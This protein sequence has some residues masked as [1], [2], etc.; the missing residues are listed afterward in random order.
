MSDMFLLHKMKLKKFYFLSYSFTLMYHKLIKMNVLKFGGSSVKDEVNIS[1][2]LDILVKRKDK[3]AVVFSAMGGVTDQLI[4]LSQLASKKD[5]SYESKFKELKTRHLSTAKKLL[6][7]KNYQIA[8]E[9]L[10]KTHSNLKKILAGVSILG[11][12]SERTMDYIVSFG[13]RT[14]AFIIALA[15]NERKKKAEYLDARQ[16]IVTDSNHG[17]ASLIKK[18]SYRKIRAYFKNKTSIQIIT[19][20]IASDENGKTTTLGRGGS[21]YTAAILGEALKAKSIE[22][23]TDV[24]GILSADPRK[25]EEAFT[26]P[27]VS[28]QE[29][30]EL[31]HFGAKVIYPP[32]IKPA[33]DSKIPVFIK[34][35]FNPDFKGT[36]IKDKSWS[37]DKPVI[38]ISAVSDVLLLS[39]E[40][41]GMIGVPG[42]AARLFG[43]LAIK[44]INIILI[45]Q[46]SSEHAITF[47]VNPK[48]SKSAIQI[49]ND[50]FSTEIEK[51]LIKEI[52]AESNLSVVAVIGENMK[53]TPGI[54]AKLFS[55]MGRNGINIAAIAQGSSELNISV[56]IKKSQQ[57][58]ALN[59]LHEAF[60]KD[61]TK[62]IH[63]Y[64]VG[65]G[66]IG[67]KLIEQ[68]NSQ[69]EILKNKYG[70]SLQICAMAN[71]RKM[72]FNNVQTDSEN[73]SKRLSSSRKKMNIS[74]FVEHMILENRRNAIFVDNTSSSDVIKEYKNILSNSIS[75]S[76]PNKLGA[77]SIIKDFNQLKK[78]AAQ[79]SVVYGYETNVGAGLPILSTIQDLIKS[80]DEIQKI[81][82]VLSGS[83]SYIFNNFNG[84]Q[85]FS[86]IVSEAKEK[87]LTEPD[88]RDDLNGYDVRRKILILARE[89]GHSIEEKEINIDYFLKPEMRKAKTINQFM[90]LLKKEDNNLQKYIEGLNAQNK[91]A[92]MIASFSNNSA[93]VGVQ[94]VNQSSPFYS[95]E[96]SDNMIVIHS[97]RY[98]VRPLVIRGPG[99]GA[100][101]TAAGVLAEILRIS[102]SI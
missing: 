19:G 42:I 73:W 5:N 66:L 44:E 4:E 89:A 91:K 57:K 37:H 47:A 59:V 81:E 29:A 79:R 39:L 77:S 2:V 96:G 17:N 80:G 23:W 82:A 41:A 78:I 56:V 26:I 45:T 49:I 99:A 69:Q 25:V 46:C 38:G 63:L 13:E 84:S 68:I 16:I 20:F 55:A 28:Y 62:D 3:I 36:V 102:N 31:S 40:G 11:E 71:S 93:K 18:K 35:T 34:N 7:Q 90:S 27:Q 51:G 65:V 92:R 52:I 61:D 8:K 64:I 101:V 12:I 97:K 67:G 95:L 48:D 54:S 76:T 74:K 98:N 100:D 21:D 88:P 53:S 70:I 22:I 75:I 83:L 58:K 94:E 9:E 32:T 33:L 87:G 50:T 15:L 1:K 10:S 14:S 24:D 43:A 60:F 85:A 72:V 30:M 6:S 86:D